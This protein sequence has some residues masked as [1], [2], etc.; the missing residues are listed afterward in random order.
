MKVRPLL[1]GPLV[2]DRIALVVLAGAESHGAFICSA[3]GNIP[4]DGWGATEVLAARM[5]EGA[6]DY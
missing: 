3:I 1:T 5:G 2:V 4:A 6:A